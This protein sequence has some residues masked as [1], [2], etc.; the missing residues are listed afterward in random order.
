MLTSAI[1]LDVK[2]SQQVDCLIAAPAA[3]RPE[4]VLHISTM[5]HTHVRLWNGWLDECNPIDRLDLTPARNRTI[6]RSVDRRGGGS[7]LVREGGPG[8]LIGNRSV[9]RGG[10]GGIRDS[11]IGIHMD[12]EDTT[13]TTK[14]VVDGA[15][16]DL[17]DVE[18]AKH[19]GTHDARLDGDVEGTL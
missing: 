18:L 1:F 13:G 6:L 15:E 4:P 5:T 2:L 7:S 9:R 3:L 12:A 11:D 17:L 14:L 8:D 16:I 19:G 10:R